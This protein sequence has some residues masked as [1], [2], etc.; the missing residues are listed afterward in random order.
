MYSLG[1]VPIMTSDTT[2]SGTASA[3]SIYD[4][5][6]PAWKAFDGNDESEAW[7]RWI[8]VYDYGFTTPQWLS[9][10]FTSPRRI[11]LYYILPEYGSS[12]KDRS[13]KNWTL[14]GWN[15]STWVTLDTR[16]NI[17]NDSVWNAGGLH[18]SV[19]NP[20]YYTKYRLYVTAVNGSD[21]VS[22]R[23]FKLFL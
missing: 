5:T 9:Y 20:G 7:S 10:E 2:P 15:G 1:E 19:T 23:Q 14:E 12:T 21:V 16:T 13:P 17:L 11:D 6:Y 3:S 22:I 18:F 4:S 8:S